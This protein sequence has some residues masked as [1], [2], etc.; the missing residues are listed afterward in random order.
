MVRTRRAL[1]RLLRDGN[2][3]D[4]TD[5]ELIRLVVGPIRGDGVE[6]A[7][8]SLFAERGLPAPGEDDRSSGV[9]SDQAWAAT[10]REASGDALPPGQ[11][12]RL[13]A[14]FELSR[15]FS[16]EP[17]MPPLVN[18]PREVWGVTADLRGETREHFVGLYLNARN[19]LLART[20]VS[21]GSLN[22]ALVHPREVFA[23]ALEVRAASLIVV[24]NHPSG[25][26]DPSD[27][28]VCI[29]RRLA[30]AGEILGVRL[31]DHVIVGWRG[32]TSLR[33]AGHL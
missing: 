7:A 20:T 8:R 9:A 27:D 12:A 21:I 25:E 29:T 2:A 26:T 18:T 33:E 31:V 28:D 19:R 30:D 14:A 32:Y 24:H 6:R 13:A 22:A 15:R 23:P 4:L 1:V 11:A 3:Q 10:P 16:P 17:G 5:M